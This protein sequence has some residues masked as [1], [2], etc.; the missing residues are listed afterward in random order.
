MNIM[1]II[2][3]IYFGP[4]IVG[5]LPLIKEGVIRLSKKTDISTSILLTWWP[6]AIVLCGLAIVFG[7]LFLIAVGGGALIDFALQAAYHLSGKEAD[8]RPIW[9]KD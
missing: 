2:L 5:H 7:L 6:L 1:I 4:L 9:E 8:W 3:I